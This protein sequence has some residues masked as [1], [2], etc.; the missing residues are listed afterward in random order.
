MRTWSEARNFASQI[1]RLTPVE[2]FSKSSPTDISL[3]TGSGAELQNPIGSWT[4][5]PIIF[6]SG[7]LFVRFCGGWV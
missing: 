6:N 4:G 3:D 2:F 7:V 5:Y 1:F